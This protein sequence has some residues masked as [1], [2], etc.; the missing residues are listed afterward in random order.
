MQLPSDFPHDRHE[1]HLVALPLMLLTEEERLEAVEVVRWLDI[2]LETRR[3]NLVCDLLDEGWSVSAIARLLGL[4]PALFR[5][6][7]VS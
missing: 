1:Q 2:W 3:A 7:P 6:P 5:P 4:P